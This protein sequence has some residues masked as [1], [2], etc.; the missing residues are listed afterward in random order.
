MKEFPAHY[1]THLRLVLVATFGDVL[2]CQRN[3]MSERYHI[4]ARFIPSKLN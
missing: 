4:V 1:T 2:V 3:L